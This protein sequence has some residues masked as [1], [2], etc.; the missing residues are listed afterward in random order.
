MP[1]EFVP[2]TETLQGTLVTPDLREIGLDE[3]T[4]PDALEIGCPTRI[5]ATET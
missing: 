4:Q 2:L 3:T 1:A 5:E